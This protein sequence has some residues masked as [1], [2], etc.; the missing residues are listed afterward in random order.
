MLYSLYQRRVRNINEEIEK[1]WLKILNNSSPELIDEI[2]ED[3][4]SNYCCENNLDPHDYEIL[5]LPDV[6]K[7]DKIMNIK[8][9]EMGIVHEIIDPRHI[10]VKDVVNKRPTNIIRDMYRWNCVDVFV[11]N[12]NEP[13]T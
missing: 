6:Y 10:M 1:E 3:F 5:I 4:V 2:I 13:Q 8:T 12:N 7:G 9:Q 11:L